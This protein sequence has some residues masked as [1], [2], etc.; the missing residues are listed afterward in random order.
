MSRAPGRR[1]IPTGSSWWKDISFFG[2]MPDGYVVVI[3][4][5]DVYS[6]RDRYTWGGGYHKVHVTGPQ[7]RPRSKAFIGE[8]AWSDAER[9]AEDV[10]S[11]LQRVAR[12]E[13][14]WLVKA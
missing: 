3:E 12:G 10:V 11:D 5:R 1:Y 2:H 7:P 13:K 4:V 6:E 8:T 9:Y 14:S